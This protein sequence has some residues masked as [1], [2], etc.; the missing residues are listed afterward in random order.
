M[1]KQSFMGNYMYS[2][3]TPMFDHVDANTCQSI[4]DALKSGIHPAMFLPN[5]GVGYNM[6]QE[7][8]LR[9][10]FKTCSMEEKS[11]YC[12]LVCRAVGSDPDFAE[13]FTCPSTDDYTFIA[14]KMDSNL[15]TVANCAFMALNAP[16][17][18]VRQQ[19]KSLFES[20]GSESGSKPDQTVWEELKFNE[21]CIKK[22]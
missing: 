3:P 22:D 19:Y 16:T 6:S 20:F 18:S 5:F 1:L 8:S 21:G 17:E 4:K 2:V 13:F 9:E 10:Y 11:K 12:D 15:T 14:K 7:S